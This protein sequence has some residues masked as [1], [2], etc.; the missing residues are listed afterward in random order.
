MILKVT[1]PMLLIQS[2]SVCHWFPFIQ[3]IE[4]MAIKTFGIASQ[5]QQVCEVVKTGINLRDGKGLEISIL[6]VPL[7]C[8][9]ISNQPIALAIESCNEF[10]S[11]QL[12]DS[13]L[14]DDNLEADIL[15]GSGQYYKLVTREV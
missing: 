5:N 4:T 11:L 2:R 6:S 12:A 9:H 7:I 3:K 15:I 14:G 8:N 1:D 13:S 10:A